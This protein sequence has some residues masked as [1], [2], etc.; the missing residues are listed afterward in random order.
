MSNAA[1]QAVVA[2]IAARKLREIVAAAF[3]ID[4]T[5][6]ELFNGIDLLALQIAAETVE[7]R[8]IESLLREK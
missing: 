4:G 7:D 2:I 3:V 1:E 5:D 6:I 8:A